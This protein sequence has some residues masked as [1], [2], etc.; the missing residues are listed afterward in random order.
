MVEKRL[1][2]LLDKV[3]TFE[4]VDRTS[5]KVDKTSKEEVRRGRGKR[6][7]EVG[8]R[9]SLPLGCRRCKVFFFFFYY[10][11]ERGE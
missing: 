10:G 11:R 7:G 2:E 3:W 9:D 4:E 6:K 5:K 1:M 8:G